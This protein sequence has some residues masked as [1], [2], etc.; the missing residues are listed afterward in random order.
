MTLTSDKQEFQVTLL[1]TKPDFSN[2]ELTAAQAETYRLL[3]AIFKI[4]V[5]WSSREIM[6]LLGLRDPRPVNSRIDHL[7]EKGWLTLEA[8]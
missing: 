8:V 7:A 5:C 1:K 2:N 3:Q 4:R 6:S